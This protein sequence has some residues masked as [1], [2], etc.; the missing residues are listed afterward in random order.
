MYSVGN[1]ATITP[2]LHGG[3]RIVLRK[4]PFGAVPGTHCFLWLPGVRSTESHP[5]TIIST[6][7]LEMVVAAYDGFTRD[8][9]E[10]SLKNPGQELKASVDRPYSSVPDFTVFNKII[11]IAGGS[12][13]S[14]TCGVAVDTLRKLGH[15][16]ATTI[17][18]IW[19]VRDQGMSP[20]S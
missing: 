2:L 7:P 6:N 12:G 13:A 5:F 17:D 1:T 15:S 10:R 3:T 8:L 20:S 14:F 16:R 18:F 19:V 4:T 11:L 9:H